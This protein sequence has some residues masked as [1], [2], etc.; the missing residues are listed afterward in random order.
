MYRKINSTFQYQGIT[1]LAV[2]NDDEGS[3]RTATSISMVAAKEFLRTPETVSHAGG[4]TT[5]P[6]I[7][8]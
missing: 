8:Q 3:I 4:K 2:E 5:R 6:Y 1:L 7:L